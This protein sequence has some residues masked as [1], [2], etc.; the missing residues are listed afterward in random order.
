MDHSFYGVATL[1]SVAPDSMG[2]FAEVT[3]F[4]SAFEGCTGLETVP[5][6]LF[7]SAL[8]VNDFKRCFYGVNGVKVESPYTVI[9][10][11]KV[12]LY[13]RSGYPG[14]ASITD[15]RFCFRNGDWADMEQI[16]QYKGWY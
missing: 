4:E 10:G 5:V 7:D 14:F 1:R 13:E 11:T 9:D 2:A 8:Q 15:F 6:S 16:M 3:T 12:H